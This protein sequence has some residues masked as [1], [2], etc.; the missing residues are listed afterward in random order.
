ML[1][2]KSKQNLHPRVLSKYKEPAQC[3]GSYDLYASTIL[4]QP[5]FNL[6]GISPE[7]VQFV[8]IPFLL[9]E[10]MENR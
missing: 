10:H 2:Q 3:A 4:I 5:N 6:F 1:L 7:F 8:I 9:P